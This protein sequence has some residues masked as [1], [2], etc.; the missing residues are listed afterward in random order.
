[1]PVGAE[2][3]GQA[4]DLRRR[5]LLEDEQLGRVMHA[6]MA[7]IYERLRRYPERA[8]R[9]ELLVE[10]ARRWR[11]APGVFRLGFDVQHDRTMAVL[12]ERRLSAGKMERLDDPEWHGTEQA[13]AIVLTEFLAWKAKTKM[14]ETPLALFSLHAIARR[15]QRA[16]A[17]CTDA[18]LISDMALVGEVD[19]ASIGIGEG[20]IIH[21]A[22]GGWRG[23]VVRHTRDD[24]EI[25][26]LIAVRTWLPAEAIADAA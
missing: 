1:M 18:M 9:P 22:D 24:G 10:L 4:R 14:R 16:A 5:V 11:A 8:L 26:R 19:V 7:P 25:Q 20:F 17:L 23:R 12:T 2:F 6:A 3:F 21:T 13:I 15:L